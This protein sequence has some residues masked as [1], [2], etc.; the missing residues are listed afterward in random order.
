MFQENSQRKSKPILL[1]IIFCSKNRAA[2]DTT[3]KNIIKPDRPQ[4]IRGM[5]IACWIPKAT[6]THSNH[7]VSTATMLPRKRRNVTYLKI[8]LLQEIGLIYINMASVTKSCVLLYYYYYL[9]QLSFHSVTAVLTLVQTKQIRIN[10]HKPNDTKHSKY[11][12]TY[13]QNTHTIVKTSPH[14]P[15]HTLQNPHMH[16]HITKQVKTTTVQDTHQ[17][18]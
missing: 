8:K 11:K 6:D 14:T 2:C 17:I 12:Y 13:Y 5:R 9:L 10:I 15:T 16:P 4:I 7:V 3:W 1:S 18:K